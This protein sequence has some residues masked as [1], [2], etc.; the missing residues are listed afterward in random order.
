LLVVLLLL[1]DPVFAGAG[2]ACFVAVF[3]ADKFENGSIDWDSS[4]FCISNYVAPKQSTCV[5]YQYLYYTWQGLFWITMAVLVKIR[6]E[7][8]WRW[9]LIG[10][11]MYLVLNFAF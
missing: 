2:F 4:H 10:T 1:L 3:L 11:I 6:Q 9:G 7:V 5:I 8:V